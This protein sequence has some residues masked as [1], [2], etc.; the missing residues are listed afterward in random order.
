[1]DRV[2]EVCCYYISLLRSVALVH[3]NGH[4]LS[5]GSN[6][7]GNHLLLDRIYKTAAED[8][9]AAVERF[10]GLFGSEVLDLQMQSQMIGKTLEE[11]SDGSPLDASLEIEKKFIAFSEKFYKLLEKEDKLTLGLEDMLPAIASNRETAV[12]L[13]Q[14]TLKGTPE[15]NNMSSK[16]STRIKLLKR[17]KNAATAGMGFDPNELQRKLLTHL[18]AVVPSFVPGRYDAQDIVVSVDTKTSRIM[19][20]VKL[21]KA[22]APELQK[23]IEDNFKATAMDLLPPEMKTSFMIGIGFAMPPTGR[24]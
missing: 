13:L 21:P 11:F 17:F 9:D 10:V 4:W 22:V 7:Y 3:Q 24:I 23:K 8:A 20:N 18:S 12:Y 1:M 14:Q 6:F 19:A 16:A 15:G 2:E 5:K